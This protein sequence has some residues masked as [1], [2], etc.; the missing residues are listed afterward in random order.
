ML[1][2]TSEELR[3][4]HI[5]D[6]EAKYS[7]EQLLEMVR[8]VSVEGQSFLTVQRRK[9]GSVYDAEISATRIEWGGR[10][11]VLCTARDITERLRL[12]AELEQ[13]R[14]GPVWIVTPRSRR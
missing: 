1:G 14:D 7:R 12:A 9:D 6:W 13:H 11:Y 3:Q 5:A 10:N 8:N 2:Y 4:L